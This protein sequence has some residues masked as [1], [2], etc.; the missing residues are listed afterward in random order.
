M[1]EAN[2]LRFLDFTNNIQTLFNFHIWHGFQIK[3]EN[4][5]IIDA[6]MDQVCKEEIWTFW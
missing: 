5:Q 1:L 2:D 4:Q 6:I 3:M